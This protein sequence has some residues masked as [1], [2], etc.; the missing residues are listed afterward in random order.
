MDPSTP[1]CEPPLLAR[2]GLRSAV[3]ETP[4]GPA[5][6]I[7][8]VKPPPPTAPEPAQ[9]PLSLLTVDDCG[10]CA[11]CLDK[12]KFG[13]RGMKKKGC[14]T[15]RDRRLSGP[16]PPPDFASPAPSVEQA[17]PSCSQASSEPRVPSRLG[18]NI[19]G[20]RRTAEFV[21]MM[22][23][24]GKTQ[25]KC[26]ARRNDDVRSPSAEP[27]PSEDEDERSCSPTASAC[28]DVVLT[29]PD[30]GPFKSVRMIGDGLRSESPQ[31]PL[32]APP[33][34]LSASKDR[35]SRDMS[36]PA[37]LAPLRVE[38]DD[39][40][41]D[42]LESALKAAMQSP[43]SEFANYLEMTPRMV[44][45]AT[46]GQPDSLLWQLASLMEKTPR[47]PTQSKLSLS[48]EKPLEPEE[49]KQV[50]LESSLQ[51]TSP[52]ATP[53]ET[54]RALDHALRCA[55]QLASPNLS[56]LL[57][58]VTRSSSNMLIPPP[59]AAEDGGNARKRKLEGQLV[60]SRSREEAL[61]AGMFDDMG[62]FGLE[63]DEQ[64]ADMHIN[65][66]DLSLLP[67]GSGRRSSSG[68]ARPRGKAKE[69]EKGK[70]TQ[71]KC[72]KSNCLKRYCVCFQAGGV[73]GESCKCKGCKNNDAEENREERTKKVAE[74]QK[75]KTNAFGSR[76]T[77]TQQGAGEKVHHTGCHCKKSNCRKRYCECF[78][79]GV[80]CTDKCKCS[81]CC[82]PKGV[83]ESC[84][85]HE[86][87]AVPRANSLTELTTLS[88]E[89]DDSQRQK[90]PRLKS[91]S[92]RDEERSPGTVNDLIAAAAA[93]E[94][95]VPAHISNNGALERLT[96][97]NG[98]LERTASASM[99]VVSLAAARSLASPVCEVDLPDRLQLAVPP[100]PSPC[101]TEDTVGNDTLHVIEAPAR[102]SSPLAPTMEHIVGVQ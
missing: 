62:D 2:P 10:Q 19:L 5:D 52:S 48:A 29:P 70:P 23:S 85:R 83:N 28:A 90:S 67:F 88:D 47:L 3:P 55:S 33:S 34:Q 95:A 96:S 60:R 21:S 8:D 20:A 38:G 63:D 59:E 66:D 44:E 84:N 77:E 46:R 69:K 6:D 71:C 17:Q 13:G 86:M 26:A 68:S 37:P 94:A 65:V 56:A 36:T 51:T 11:H 43:L 27:G 49:A 22:H 100:S 32:R 98:A 64:F 92:L 42:G 73:C 89:D 4:S 7:D 79:Y 12:P 61:D 54:R 16:L 1:V 35:S 78:T 50:L 93:A 24:L 9:P 82:N 91:P 102:K 75:K 41:H 97:Y 101:G 99:E 31:D 74:M 87:G 18:G 45:G 53:D 40:L 58:S 14:L 15:K 39:A 76:V 80:K 57:A 30:G 25:E 72:D 81:D